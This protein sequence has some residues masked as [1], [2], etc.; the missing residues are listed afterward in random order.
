M[1]W[2]LQPLS[3]AF[4]LLLVGQLW[5]WRQRPVP[6]LAVA[7]LLAGS[8]LLWIASAPLTANGFVGEIET[9]DHYRAGACELISNRSPVV[10]LGAGLDA[11]VDSDNPYEVLDRDTLM[12]TLRATTLDSGS[13]TFYLLGGGQ[14][15]RKLSN[16]MAIIMTQQ[17]VDSDRIITESESKSTLDNARHLTRLLPPSDAATIMLVTSALHANRASATFR[18]QGYSVCPVPVDPLYSVSAGWVGL[19]PHIDGLSKSTRAW[20]EWLATR[21]Y[22]WRGYT[23]YAAAD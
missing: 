12:R 4:V 6:I 14:T 20:R 21:L 15:S 19:M 22:E 8:C 17:G 16:F 18:T 3:L 2:F 10:V 9:P 11:Y 13:Q 23:V 5:L 7:S 1:D